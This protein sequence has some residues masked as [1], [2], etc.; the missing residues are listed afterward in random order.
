MGRILRP[1]LQARPSGLLRGGRIIM[2]VEEE[3][4]KIKFWADKNLNVKIP[5]N[6]KQIYYKSKIRGSWDCKK[7][8]FIFSRTL[9]ARV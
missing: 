3:W 4:I 8:S 1:L 7:S 5:H 6:Q 2:V 9:S